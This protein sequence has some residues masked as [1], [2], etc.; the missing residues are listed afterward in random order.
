MTSRPCRNPYFKQQTVPQI[1]DGWRHRLHNFRFSFSQQMLSDLAPSITN[2]S[3]TKHKINTQLPQILCSKQP[4]AKP[5]YAPSMSRMAQ[6][7]NA[8]PTNSSSTKAASFSR[9][10]AITSPLCRRLPPL[11]RSAGQL[12]SPSFR[13]AL[14]RV[15]SHSAP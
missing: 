15:F 2:L 7:Q 10:H 4:P 8:S 12:L 1:S 9:L 13:F 5:R 14:L 3:L 11:L 6:T